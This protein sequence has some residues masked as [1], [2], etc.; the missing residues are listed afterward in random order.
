MAFWKV[1]VIFTTFLAQS[2]PSFAQ[3]PSTS[4]NTYKVPDGSCLKAAG[5]LGSTDIQAAKAVDGKTLEDVSDIRSLRSKAK[6]GQAIVINGGDFS[7]K[8]FG[9]DNFSKAWQHLL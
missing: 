4:Q 6:D 8:K 5:A 9:N 2:V 1:A 3:K 7:G